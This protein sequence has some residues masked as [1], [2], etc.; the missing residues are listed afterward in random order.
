MAMAGRL[1][2]R[3]KRSRGVSPAA[4]GACSS[5]R[6]ITR[7][8][9]YRRSRRAGCAAYMRTVIMKA[10]STARP[11]PQPEPNALM[12]QPASIFF[13]LGHKVSFGRECAKLTNGYLG[14]ING[15]TIYDLHACEGWS[16]DKSEPYQR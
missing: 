7:P 6:N 4:S 1:M 15:K 13:C 2:A 8:R 12:C 3:L 5:G 14:S 9:R 16:R 11:R 10:E